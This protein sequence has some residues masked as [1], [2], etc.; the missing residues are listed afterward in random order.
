MSEPTFRELVLAITVAESDARAALRTRIGL[1]EVPAEALEVALE[2]YAWD[3]AHRANIDLRLGPLSGLTIA[4]TPAQ[5]R[6]VAREMSATEDLL[7]WA[8]QAERPPVRIVDDE[9]VRAGRRLR[10]ES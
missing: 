5:R 7:E 3:A 6:L 9:P 2:W 4:S 1:G 10:G 8:R